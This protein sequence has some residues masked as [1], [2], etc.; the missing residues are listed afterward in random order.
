M[1]AS[2]KFGNAVLTCSANRATALTIRQGN[3]SSIAGGD[4]SSRDDA[5]SGLSQLEG[6]SE[7]AVR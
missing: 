5:S 2:N 1:I 7:T 3:A 4:V 6:Q